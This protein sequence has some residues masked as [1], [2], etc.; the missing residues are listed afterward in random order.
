MGQQDRNDRQ[1]DGDPRRLQD[2]LLAFADPEVPQQRDVHDDREREV[3][4]VLKHAAGATQDLATA[5]HQPP[6]ATLDAKEPQRDRDHPEHAAQLLASIALADG[7]QRDDDDL[8]VF[9]EVAAGIGVLDLSL[10]VT[11]GHE[12]H[13][14]AHHHRPRL[15]DREPTPA[16]FVDPPTS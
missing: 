8:R 15:P 9:E 12:R 11:D 16:K 13:Q 1:E 3:I 7:E 2:P 5:A 14:D 4:V 6:Q 10:E